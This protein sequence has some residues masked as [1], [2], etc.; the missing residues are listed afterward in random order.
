VDEALEESG[1]LAK[2]NASVA[3]A[4]DLAAC[5]GYGIFAPRAAKVDEARLKAKLLST[6]WNDDKS[7]RK[8]CPN[9]CG[10]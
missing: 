1:F 7:M 9:T 4:V 3:N 2:K 8:N 5:A 6:A 10:N